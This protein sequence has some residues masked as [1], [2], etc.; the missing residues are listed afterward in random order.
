MTV[1]RSVRS[2]FLLYGVFAYFAARVF[3]GLGATTE[4]E[5][6]DAVDE[7]GGSNDVLSRAEAILLV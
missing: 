7:G 2:G 4:D 5:V 3:E 6:E 1:R